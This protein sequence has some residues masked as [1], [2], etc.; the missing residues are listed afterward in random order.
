MYKRES[1]SKISKIIAIQE[2]SM[3]WMDTEQREV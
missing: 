3:S 2:K 1:K